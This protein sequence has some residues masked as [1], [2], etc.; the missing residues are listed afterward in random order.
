[1]GACMPEGAFE[2]EGDKHGNGGPRA[3]SQASSSVL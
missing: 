2:D 1:M 3:G